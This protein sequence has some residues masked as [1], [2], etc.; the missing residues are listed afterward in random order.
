MAM[1]NKSTKNPGTELT[2][3]EH[4]RKA[5]LQHAL[6]TSPPYPKTKKTDLL[7]KIASICK[8]SDLS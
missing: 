6:Q 8:N 5:W 2:A 4:H 7:R 3:E 1:Q